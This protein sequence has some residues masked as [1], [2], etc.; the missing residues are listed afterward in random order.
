MVLES[1]MGVNKAIEDSWLKTIQDFEEAKKIGNAWLWTEDTLRLYFFHHLCQS[2]RISR[3]LAETTFH[4]GEEDYKPDL[5]VDTIVNGTSETTVFEIKYSGREWEA[6]WQKLQKYGIIGWDYGYFLA[7][8]RPW[9]CDAIPKK[10]QKHEILEHVYE[11]RALV[12]PTPLLAVMP[13]FKIAEELLKK[14][15]IGVPYVVSENFG[16]VAIFEK[17]VICFYMITKENKCII[18]VDFGEEAVDE[19]KL[20]KLG[21]GKWI[22]FDDEDRIQLVESFTGKALIGEFEANTYR[23]NVEKVKD[24][25]NQFR[26]K[27]KCL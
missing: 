10:V 16:A 17:F 24:S 12:Y 20:G 14:A 9:Q 4:I 1:S 7:I 25:L 21:Y 26:E 23:D 11:I 22:S 6:D 27:I 18:W 3:I 5:V 19:H 8:G 2:I 15:L 13:N